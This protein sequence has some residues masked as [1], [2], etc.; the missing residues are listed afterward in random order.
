MEDITPTTD[1]T[2]LRAA[3]EARGMTREELA[4]RAHVS[5]TTIERLENERT[6]KPH[7]VTGHSIATVLGCDVAD[8]WPRQ[9]EAA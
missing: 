6:A 1:V 5:A 9:E 7:R 8:L 2:P 3:R 4:F